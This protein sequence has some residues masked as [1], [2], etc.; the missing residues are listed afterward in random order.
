MGR[1]KCNRY[2]IV[3]CTLNCP[4]T[5]PRFYV[6]SNYWEIV[7]LYIS[8]KTSRRVYSPRPSDYDHNPNTPSVILRWMCAMGVDCSSSGPARMRRRYLT[9]NNQTRNNSRSRPHIRVGRVYAWE[10]IKSKLKLR[11]VPVDGEKYYSVESQNCPSMTRVS[12]VLLN[13][14]ELSKNVTTYDPSKS[15]PVFRTSF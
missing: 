9:R 10:N 14:I 5:Y 13:Q 2:I 6:F 8:V 12:F 11:R 7:F 1:T 3:R 4:K 15:E